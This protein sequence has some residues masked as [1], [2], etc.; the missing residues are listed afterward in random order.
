T[1]HGDHDSFGNA[2]TVVD[3]LGNLTTREYDARGRLFHQKDTMG[4]ETRTV[5]DGLDRATR[6]FKVAGGASDDEVTTT[7]YYPGGQPRTVKNANG[8]VTTYTLDGLNRVIATSTALTG[9]TLTTAASYDGNG[10]RVT[11]MDRRGVTRRNTH[12]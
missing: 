7:S 4:H 3:P 9:E 2:R 5:Y 12:D 1:I 10:N 8:A 11:E 6:V